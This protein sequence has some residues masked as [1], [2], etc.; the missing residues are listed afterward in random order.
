MCADTSEDYPRFLT[1][2]TGEALTRS[3]Y[4]SSELSAALERLYEA[5][6]KWREKSGGGG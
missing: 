4:F 6:K 5:H 1:D 3:V 2:V